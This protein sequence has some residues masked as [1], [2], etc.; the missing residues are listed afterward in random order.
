M[1]D[2]LNRRQSLLVLNRIIKLGA[3]SRLKYMAFRD[4]ITAGE[5]TFPL[6]SRR[7][8][9]PQAGPRAQPRRIPPAPT[10]VAS[11]YHSGRSDHRREP[12]RRRREGDRRAQSLFRDAQLAAARSGVILSG[13][14]D[15]PSGADGAASSAANEVR[16]MAQGAKL[17]APGCS[18]H[19]GPGTPVRQLKP[20]SR[21]LLLDDYANRIRAIAG[22]K[23]GAG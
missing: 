22:R 2:G 17:Q 12:G 4:S 18:C 11:R 15:I 5:V 3:A 7:A 1:T 6:D 13:H 9:L 16:I 21:S 14:N 19:A 20:S 23:R 10:I 8:D